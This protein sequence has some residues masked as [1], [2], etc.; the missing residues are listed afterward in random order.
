MTKVTELRELP[1][2]QLAERLRELDDKVFRLRL[3]K[4]MGQTEAANQMPGMRRD[5]ARVKTLLREREHAQGVDAARTEETKS[6]D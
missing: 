1:T 2:D 4:S 5:R 6:G 3:Q